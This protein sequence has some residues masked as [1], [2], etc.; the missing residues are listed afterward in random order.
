MINF[1]V[2]NLNDVEER[3]KKKRKK[4]KNPKV[5]SWMK[6][7]RKINRQGPASEFF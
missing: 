5:Y 1:E 2:E 6:R 3:E 7:K 4:E